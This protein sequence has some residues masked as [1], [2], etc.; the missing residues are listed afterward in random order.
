MLQDFVM[1][2]YAS[3]TAFSMQNKRGM[4]MTLGVIVTAILLL[5]LLGFGLYQVGK[6]GFLVSS[7]Y[8]QFELQAQ[9]Q[10]CKAQAAMS[11]TF[12]DNDFSNNQGDGFPD[13]CDICL[14]GDNNRDS[15]ND[16]MPDACDKD[17]NN[18]PAK[19][20]TMDKICTGTWNKAKM[21]C[22]LQCYKDAL[23]NPNKA[24]KRI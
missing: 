5:A 3:G 17:P 13:S 8:N 16:G 22:T 24:C 1:F 2:I 6:G 23:T 15:D 21:Q 20:E 19:G 10:S 12:F 9:T 11:P 4:E 7:K 14:G 18:P